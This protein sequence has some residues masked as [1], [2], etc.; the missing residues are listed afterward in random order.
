M[1]QNS[2][3]TV[4][5][6]SINQV[7]EE[8]PIPINAD[9]SLNDPHGPRRAYDVT[10]PDPHS[11]WNLI[12]LILK[13]TGLI[14]LQLN[15]FNDFIDYGLTKIMNANREVVF[16][17][18]PRILV[19]YK[20]IYVDRPTH[21]RSNSKLTPQQCRLSD[22]NYSANV[23]VDYDLYNGSNVEHQTRVSIARLPIMLQSNRCHLYNASNEEYARLDECPY[24][25]GGYFVI[26]GSERV[27]H[28]QEQSPYNRI[29]IEH[30]QS[31]AKVAVV[32]SSTANHK[33]RIELIWKKDKLALHHNALIEDIPIFVLFR[34]LG[35][36]S[37]Q[38]IIQLIDPTGTIDD[39]L[40][41]SLQEIIQLGI[42]T[43][44]E[45]LSL[46]DKRIRILSFTGIETSQQDRLLKN[47]KAREFLRSMVLPHIPST[48]KEFKKKAIFIGLMTRWLLLSAR[49]STM[50]DGRDFFG[51]KRLELA[52]ELLEL[53]FEDLFKTF[54]STMQKTVSRAFRSKTIEPRRILDA[55]R[56]EIIT[57][58]LTYAISSG[59]WNITRF[60]MM[61]AGVSQL[62]GRMS[63]L[64]FVTMVTRI[65]SHFE[66]TQKISGARSLY[67]SQFGFICPSDTPEGAQ[68]GLIKNFSLTAHVTVWADPSIVR[69][70]LFDLGVQEISLFSG[71]EISNSYVIMLN[72]DP[73]G[74]THN[75]ATICDRFRKLRRSRW[76]DKYTAIWVSE[77]KKCI[78][79]STE[80]GRICRPLI[81]VENRKSK[82][83][84][85]H[86][87]G[88]MDGSLTFDYLTDNG[89]IEF[90]DINEMHDC[91]IAFKDELIPTDNY[92][93]AEIDNAQILGVCA[94]V[95]PCPHNNQ[96]PRNTYQCAMG[97]QAIGP[98]A[99]NIMH[100]VDK[101]TYFNCYPQMPMV[102]TR[103]IRLSRYNE[104][105]CGQNAMVAIMSYSGYDIE[106]ALVMNKASLDR[107]FGRR[108]Y[109]SKLD[110]MLK[111]YQNGLVSDQ[112]VD[113]DRDKSVKTAS[114]QYKALDQ[115]GIVNPG[116]RLERGQV[117]ANKFVP[118]SFDTN[119]SLVESRARYKSKYPVMVQHV[120]IATTT[121]GPVVK[122]KT[123][124]FRRPEL[125]DKFSS[126]HGQKGVLG[127]IVE[128]EDMPYTEKGVFP[129]LIMNPHGFP[130]RMTV[131][132]MIE[133]VSGKAGIGNGSIGNGTA[134]SADRYRDIAEDLVAAGF[135]YS[136]KELLMSGITGEP[137]YG[138]IFFGPVFYQSLKHMVKDKMQARAIGP[139]QLLTRQ[140]TQGRNREGGMR[141]GEMERDCLIGYGA[142]SILY[143]RML[144]SSDVFNANVCAKCGFIGYQD[145]C[146]HCK[147]SEHMKIV[148]MPY[149]CKLLF[150]E[151]MSMGIAPKVRIKDL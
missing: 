85:Q 98:T 137:L 101:S 23:F 32:N 115:D 94:G 139:T 6:S 31:G 4:S 80:A 62:L 74:I 26:N 55:M 46:I 112:I 43:Q 84:Q 13:S 65:S 50:T 5:F 110:L 61:R 145:Q 87:D 96:S 89:I 12:P 42:S 116:E 27:V 54:N 95:I 97:K 66:K 107:G 19:R 83:T 120:S 67:P 39:L 48:L 135:S 138:Y 41:A 122:I 119:S 82:F 75:P 103:T 28:V 79:V 78:F 109:L 56:S 127:L 86:L 123:A 45:A 113:L 1:N 73:I 47:Y 131:G 124:D 18:S 144:L 34:A 52:G 59:N 37:D 121:F 21:P 58:G 3:K 77:P 69:R 71:E 2:H 51:N 102:Q 104:M 140:P 68:C 40:M 16:S 36:H 114:E 44:D 11:K 147:T 30:T 105:P 146:T 20:S 76:F 106:D 117:Y 64:Q 134:F 9:E 141:L 17:E 25:P 151:L 130:S 129:D 49:D 133:L 57:H 29:L 99:L 10:K 148:R 60:K 88:I 7:K 53:L 132:K 24:D 143:E 111:T 91:F 81:L 63:Y 15:S 14:R 150:H 108:Y 125:G 136:G 8:K 142:A 22:Q 70:T 38:E 149:A 100:R 35:I 92:T 33:T 93:H 118:K 128:Q 126:R 72:G 90:V